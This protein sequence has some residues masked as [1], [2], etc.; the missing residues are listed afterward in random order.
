MEYSFVEIT[1]QNYQ[2]WLAIGFDR[3]EQAKA[4]V[5][6][7]ILQDSS[8]RRVVVKDAGGVVARFS[9]ELDSQSITIWWPTIASNC[10]DA[11]QISVYASVLSYVKRLV[12][13]E[14]RKLIECSMKGT[15]FS[16][17]SL[18]IE[19]L[20]QAGFELLATRRQYN[21]NLQEK[22]IPETESDFLLQK[23]DKRSESYVSPDCLSRLIQE[24][25]DRK[26]RLEL[27]MGIFDCVSE[28]FSCYY[29]KE[30]MI[31]CVGESF[32]SEHSVA[33]N[34]YIGVSTS[35]R[36]LGIGSAT[37]H[38]QVSAQRERGF[39]VSASIIDIENVPSI[40]IHKN[41]GF[42]AEEKQIRTYVWRPM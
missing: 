1:P 24:T 11:S 26:D 42:E 7:S 14:H 21:L 6:E 29:D 9:I 4:E 23:F 10:S 15:D 39:R 31:A 36:C 33:W 12:Q 28:N 32:D 40:S 37:L 18:W 8:I 19:S 35:M 25:A 41:L 22:S 2:A 27:S 30:E 3:P 13:L 16:E 38:D 5:L 17:R 20:C 34:T